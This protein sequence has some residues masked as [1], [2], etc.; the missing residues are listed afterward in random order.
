MGL[1]K[2]DQRYCKKDHGERPT[3]DFTL[4]S[5]EILDICLQIQIINWHTLVVDET[6]SNIFQAF[7]LL[8]V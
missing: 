4:H 3:G 7:V 5:A 6:S 8:K 2:K 1:E